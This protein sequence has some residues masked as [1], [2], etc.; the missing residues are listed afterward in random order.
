MRIHTGEKPF[1]CE[2]CDY[3]CSIKGIIFLAFKLLEA[4]FR[5]FKSLYFDLIFLHLNYQDIVLDL[6][7]KKIYLK[8]SCISVIGILFLNLLK[9]YIFLNFLSS[10]I[11]TLF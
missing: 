8:F 2:L 1:Q 11:R 3:K 7:E 4:Y 9:L 5:T 10:N 6:L